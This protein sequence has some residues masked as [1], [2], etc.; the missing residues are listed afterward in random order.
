MKILSVVGA[1]PN[2]MKIAPIADALKA[3]EDVTHFLVH[4]GQ[5]YDENMSKLFFDELGIPKPDVNLGVGAGSQS[6][7]TAE[8]MVEL[9]KVMI[10]QKPDLV[11]VVGDCNSALAGAIV[12]SKLHIKLAHIEAGLRSFNWQMPEEINRIVVDKLSNLLF[13][14]EHSANENLK[15][16]GITEGVHFVG[17]VMIDTL[18]NSLEK[19]ESS[20]VLEALN[21]EAK[22]YAVLTMHRPGNVDKKE[23]LE[24]L[25]DTLAEISK[26]IKI[27]FPIHP[28]TKKMVEQFGLTEKL[29]SLQLTEPLGYLD[30]LKLNSNAKIILTDSGGIQEE[31]TILKVP[32]VTLRGETERP[33]TVEVGGSVVVGQDRGKILSAVD[34]FLNGTAPEPGV[35][36]LWDGK[37]AERIVGEIIKNA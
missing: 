25:L 17:N 28:R 34:T 13:T 14:T 30:F 16:E 35:P 27:V 26:N 11:L 3:H 37:A 23:V 1:R 36:E 15:K 19:A 22:N 12:A 9:E 29:N 33:V 21:L 32:C 10:D 18:L 5:H 31:S 20:K 8:M 7:Q 6:Q 4:T 2:F 24:G